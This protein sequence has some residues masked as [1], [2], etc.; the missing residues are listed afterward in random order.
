MWSGRLGAA[1]Q[2]LYEYR[3][4]SLQQR[5]PDFGQWPDRA[6]PT[7]CIAEFRFTKPAITEP[8]LHTHRQRRHRQGKDRS[9]WGKDQRTSRPESDLERDQ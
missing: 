8:G 2:R 6:I 7:G 5:K 3:R 9:E 1:A 4:T